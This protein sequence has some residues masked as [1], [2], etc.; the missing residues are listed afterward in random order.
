MLCKILLRSVVVTAIHFTIASANII[1]K[2]SI[3]LSINIA[4]KLAR[5]PATWASVTCLCSSVSF[6]CVT[7][8]HG[9]KSCPELE[10]LEKLEGLAYGFF[11]FFDFPKTLFQ[12]LKRGT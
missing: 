12:R 1:G 4:N 10:K 2:V 6:K 11:D 8:T 9:G 5:P 7:E 3:I